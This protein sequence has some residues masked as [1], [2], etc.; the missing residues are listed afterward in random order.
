MLDFNLIA[1][2]HCVKFFH[3]NGNEI[4]KNKNEIH[5]NKNK[6]HKNRTLGKKPGQTPDTLKSECVFY[7]SQKFQLPSIHKYWKGDSLPREK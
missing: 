7:P 4:H 5:K 1:I 6:I 3:K 2:I